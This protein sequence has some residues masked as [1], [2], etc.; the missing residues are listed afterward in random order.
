V[1]PHVELRL[2]DEDLVDVPA[3]EEG[4]IVVRGP[5]QFVGY[6][7]AALDDEALLP[8]GWFRTGDV[9]RL[10]AEGRLKIT[11]RRKDIIIRGGENI[12]S[13]E[14]EDVLATLDGVVECAVCAAPDP[15]FGEKVAAFVRCAPGRELTLE[16]VRAHFDAAGVP[17]QKAP[18]SLHVVDD[19]PRT[20]AGKV[21]KS[22]LR[23][24]LR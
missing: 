16:E 13:K 21:L 22:E 1:S 6:R 15:A 8:G 2:L 17:P 12:A 5:K 7:D 20:A 3:G 4:E 19:L 10:D 23:A 9:G 11:D 24:S 14:V 18:E